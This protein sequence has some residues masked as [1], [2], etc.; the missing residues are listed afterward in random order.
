[1]P[2][3]I[4]KKNTKGFIAN[5]DFLVLKAFGSEP[6]IH[7]DLGGQMALEIYLKNCT[8]GFEKP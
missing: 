3:G 4:F 8:V 5:L 6:Q 2:Q 7:L 1:M